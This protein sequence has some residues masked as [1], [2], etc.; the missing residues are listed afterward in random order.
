MP[1]PAVSTS[2]LEM[3]VRGDVEVA[4]QDQARGQP[5]ARLV[6]VRGATI[7]RAKCTPSRAPKSITEP[8]ATPSPMVGEQALDVVLRAFAD[9]RDD[10]QR[11][12]VRHRRRRRPR[13]TASNLSEKWR[14]LS[15]S[16]NTSPR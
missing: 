1:S 4:E 9:G 13:V 11:A 6:G 5:R 16:Q 3:R 7:S 15:F 12:L 14:I 8:L 10:R 2:S